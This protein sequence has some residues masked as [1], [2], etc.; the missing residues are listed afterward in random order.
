M[1][2]NESIWAHWTSVGLCVALMEF[3]NH[4]DSLQRW[5]DE[6]IISRMHILP[7]L[8]NLVLYGRGIS[9]YG[10]KLLE[11][12]DNLKELHL[13]DTN[14]TDKGLQSFANM[15]SLKWLSIDTANITD[16]GIAYLRNLSQLE[17]LQLA[18]TRASDDGLS[19][20]LNYPQLEYLEASGCNITEKGIYFISRVS[21]L[22]SLRIAAPAVFDDG[23]LGLAHCQRLSTLSF[24]MPLVSDGAIEELRHRLPS[25]DLTHYTFF[26]P[27]DKVLYL[28]NNFMGDNKTMY[29]FVE[30]LGATDELLNYSPFNP[31]LHTARAL[32][33]YRM[34]DIETFRADLVNV[35]DHANLYGQPDLLEMAINY[36]AENTYYGL[37]LMMQMQ[38]PERMVASKL[39]T[40]GVRPHYGRT[41]V[42]SL[43]NRLCNAAYPI[44][45]QV[46]NVPEYKQPQ[47]LLTPKQKDLILP[48][49]LKEEMKAVPWNW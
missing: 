32:L 40:A 5:T 24:D 37:R 8:H 38:H 23:F 9:D 13:V 18:N 16:S 35:R 46:Y 41:P 31:V 27:E 21:S 12:C 29:N 2:G 49:E 42:A 44:R 36:L 43:I 10:I 15:R 14:V 34:G 45:A 28:V 20:L 33:H 39:L 47:L 48:K 26:R 25:C 17:G 3:E 11:K 22:L 19:V 30:A 7:K 6:D 4:V 1:T